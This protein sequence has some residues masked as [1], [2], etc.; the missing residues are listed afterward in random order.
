MTLLST[1]SLWER[2]STLRAY[3]TLTADL[4]VDVA[5][6]GGGITGLTT[7]LS[8]AES[9]KRV[10]LLEGRRLGSGVTSNT[11]AHLTEAVDTRYHELETKLGRDSARLV[12][13]SSRAAIEKIASLASGVPC[14]FQRVHG[15]LFTNRESQLAELEAELLAAERADRQRQ[16][17][18]AA[19]H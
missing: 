6:I 18:I 1:G 17:H 13:A 15:Y 2:P 14:D 7:A 5:V 11:T 3:P 10:A 16:R 12:R 8:L 4:Q 19:L 9:G